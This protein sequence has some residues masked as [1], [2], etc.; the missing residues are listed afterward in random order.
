M[1]SRFAL[2]FLLNALWQVTLVAAVALLA[3]RLMRRGPASHRHTVLVAALFAAVALPVAS[4][5]PGEPATAFDLTVTYAPQAAVGTAPAA[6]TEAAS[7]PVPRATHRTVP[8]TDAAA[9]TLLSAYLLF[10]LYRAWRLGRAWVRTVDVRRGARVAAMPPLVHQVWRRCLRAFGQRNVELL[11]SPSISSPLTTGARRRTIILPDSLLAEPSEDVLATAIGHEMAH[12][13]RHDFPLRLLCELL[14]LPVA[15][16][17]A[18][19]IIR[20]EIERSREI[21]CDELV[22]RRLLDAGVY[23]RSI[24]SIAATMS[25]LPDAGYTL[26][27]FDG[28]ILQ[29]RI[30]RLIER[31]AANFKR[32]RLM[33]AGGLSALAICVVLASGLSLTARAQNGSQAEMKDAETAYNSGDFR[34][35]ALHFENTVKLDPANT[36]AKLFLANALMREY[37]AEDGRPG[38]PLLARAR[39]QYQGVLAYDPGNKQ[40]MQGIMALAINT[41]TPAEGRQM[42]L[43]LVETDPADKAGYYTVGVMDWA[44]VYPEYQK[45]KQAA[46]GKPE[47]YAVTD[48]TLRRNLR[49]QYLPRVEEGMQMLEKALALDGSYDDAMA[50]LNLHYRLKAA[51]TDNSA[52]ASEMIAKADEWVG[53]ALAARKEHGKNPPEP[54]AARIDVSGPPPGPSGA[55][56]VL[57]PPPPPPP[58]P[59]KGALNPAQPAT[60]APPQRAATAESPGQYW[61]VL[62]ANAAMPAMDLFRSLGAKGFQVAMLAGDDKLVRVMVGPYF[63]KAS[64]A[65]AKSDLETAGYQ[66]LRMW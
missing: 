3:Q 11:T 58:P 63:D 42:A 28:D 31:P 36:K 15:F 24:V 65:K 35:A 14:Y 10:L 6:P 37:Y 55:K 39:Q 32:A 7:T 23:A 13:A 21:A 9:L 2:T 52:E 48:A 62:G 22:T 60:A 38:S 27:V 12:I 8:F 16:H 20:R 18:A 26:G 45:A 29:E 19:W 59:S 46:G 61:Q 51:M 30:R 1:I 53:K 66:P 56:M 50:Y 33:L 64:L 40:A 34:S 54:A 5:R 43:R 4:V 57:A 47:D 41:G 17:P 49:H 25:S 44:I